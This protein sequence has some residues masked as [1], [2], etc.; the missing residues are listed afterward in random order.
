MLALA[1]VRVG[2]RSQGILCDLHYHC[3][4]IKNQA[5]DSLDTQTLEK[6]FFLERSKR[7]MTSEL[8]NFQTGF[9]CYHTNPAHTYL[10]FSEANLPKCENFMMFLN[11]MTLLNGNNP[12]L[13]SKF[14]NIECSKIRSIYQKFKPFFDRKFYLKEFLDIVL[15]PEEITFELYP[16]ALTYSARE[17]RNQSI[18]C[19]IDVEYEQKFAK[20]CSCT[21]DCYKISESVLTKKQSQKCPCS[22]QGFLNRPR[23]PAE[24]L[25]VQ[26]S[27]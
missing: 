23:M 9:E 18:L 3:D 5:F 1:A 19:R 24:Y 16:R 12:C 27:I 10:P 13:V 2:Q 17:I 6:M 21:V 26:L 22:V 11:F 20:K 14:L 8:E 15:N 25:Q 7:V 4:L